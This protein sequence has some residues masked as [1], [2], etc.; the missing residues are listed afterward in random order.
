M[1]AYNFKKLK[2]C[3]KKSFLIFLIIIFAVNF[4]E[5]QISV[6]WNDYKKKT[7]LTYN[8]SSREIKSE[9]GAI[10]INKAAK[11]IGKKVDSNGRFYNKF[12]SVTPDLK[13]Q[14]IFELSSV[15]SEKKKKKR[16]ILS[17]VILPIKKWRNNDLYDPSDGVL[18]VK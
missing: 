2:I 15:N 16:E 5:A 11:K 13:Y 10:S 1:K 14:I 18:I 6:K 7:F 4:A 17:I 8:Y 3:Q 12:T 9:F